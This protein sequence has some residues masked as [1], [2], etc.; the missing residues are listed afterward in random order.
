LIVLDTSVLVAGL[1]GPRHSGLAL[2]RALDQG[3]RILL[4]S[5]VLY[6]WLRGPRTLD[7]IADQE[8]LLPAATALPFELEDAR[9]S[10]DIY[11]AIPRARSREIDIAIAACAIR[12]EAELWTLNPRDFSDIP[13]LR[14][15]KRP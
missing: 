15:M 11:R 13:R 5:L 8:N 14:L 10:A 7:Q 3:E 6:E 2:L 12:R 4:P 1:T 9:I